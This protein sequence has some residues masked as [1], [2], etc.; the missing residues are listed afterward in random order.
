MGPQRDR[1]EGRLG[2]ERER[3]LRADHQ[4]PED[5]E[6]RV[7][8]EKRAQPVAHRVLDREF[9]RHALGELGVGSELVPDLLESGREPRGLAREALLGAGGAGVDHSA[10]GEHQRHRADR[11]V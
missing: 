7:G 3:S 9:P 1:L 11:L 4:P 6:R 2:H 8:V 10:V 5:L